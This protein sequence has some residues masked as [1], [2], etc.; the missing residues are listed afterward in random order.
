MLS[1]S[2][3]Q[4]LNL[5]KKNIYKNLHSGNSYI[6]RSE[7]EIDRK[8]RFTKNQI[9]NIC[10]ILSNELECP[11][12]NDIV[13]DKDGIVIKYYFTVYSNLFMDEPL[14]QNNF[15]TIIENAVLNKIISKLSDSFHG[16]TSIFVY[17]SDIKVLK[18]FSDEQLYN[19]YKCLQKFKHFEHFKYLKHDTNIEFYC[20]ENMFMND[21]NIKLDNKVN[22]NTKVNNI[23]VDNNTEINNTEIKVFNRLNELNSLYNELKASLSI[24]KDL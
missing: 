15:I 8:T 3:I 7:Y 14:N 20:H 22:N 11:I 4:L 6:F 19:L 16:Y 13:T 23:E 24:N 18:H 17:Y 10:N 1:L 5:I 2:E 21:P 9:K 12:N